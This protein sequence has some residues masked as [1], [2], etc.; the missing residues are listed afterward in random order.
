MRAERIV[1]ELAREIAQ[2]LQ[3]K[4]DELSEDEREMFRKQ[5]RAKVDEVRK[6][7]NDRKRKLKE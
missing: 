7:L 1:D 4:W 2:G 3:R 6:R 5:A